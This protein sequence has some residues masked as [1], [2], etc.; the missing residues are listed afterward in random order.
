MTVSK[1]ALARIIH[2]FDEAAERYDRAARVQAGIAR[3]LVDWAAPAVAPVHV[4]DLGAGTGHV[5]AALAERWPGALL[6]ALDSAPLMLQQAQRKV[7]GLNIICADAGAIDVAPRFDA[8]FSSM[9]LHWLPEPYEVAH[10]WR[11][12][13]KADGRLYLAL[14]T[15]DSFYEWRALCAG[16]GLKDGLWKM[17]DRRFADGIALRRQAQKLPVRYASAA[18]F[19]HN[20]KAIGAATP[21][22]TH[23]PFS[24]ATMRKLLQKAPRPFVVSYEVLYVELPSS[25]S[26]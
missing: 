10:R 24:P 21:R 7:R 19:L 9:M 26:V 8:M 22:A 23:K 2:N 3:R 12:G 18:A 4:L 13:L 11:R 6:T 15:E 14:L 25:R 1:S 17:P 5:A 16:E 20:L